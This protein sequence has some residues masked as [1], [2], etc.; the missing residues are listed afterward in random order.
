VLRNIRKYSLRLPQHLPQKKASAAA[1]AAQMHMQIR[2]FSKSR[3]F[4]Y[5]HA[6]A[7]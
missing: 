7:A 3:T 4:P 5:L 1:A 6:S 2:F